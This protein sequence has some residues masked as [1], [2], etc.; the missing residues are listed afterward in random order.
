MDVS[1]PFT[2]SGIGIVVDCWVADGGWWQTMATATSNE[3]KDDTDET[4]GGNKSNQPR[5]DSASAGSIK[6]PLSNR[7]GS[8]VGALAVSDG[9]VAIR[10]EVDQLAALCG[11]LVGLVIVEKAAVFADRVE[12]GVGDGDE[13]VQIV[14]VT[15]GIH[16]QGA[17]VNI[18][19][20]H[21]EVTRVER[22]LVVLFSE[23]IDRLGLVAKQK[24]G[25]PWRVAEG[26]ESVGA[27][28]DTTIVL[29]SLG[30]HAVGWHVVLP[31]K[32]G[33]F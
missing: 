9:G 31:G 4:Q 10:I 16:G 15:E 6:R 11:E 28:G 1:P 18:E 13:E 3:A 29:N 2:R 19:G 32:S 7:E 25:T 30:E 26:V 8:G 22:V 33:K 14:L 12:G 20:L 17:V 5:N 24:S 21:G 23:R 27:P